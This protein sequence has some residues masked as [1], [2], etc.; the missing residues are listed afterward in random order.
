[1]YS[2]LSKSLPIEHDW[3]LDRD[4]LGYNTISSEWYPPGRLH[5]VFLAKGYFKML[6][7]ARLYNM[8][9]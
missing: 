8:E 5:G 1:M 4:F 6:P 9:W 7:V 2:N 3:F